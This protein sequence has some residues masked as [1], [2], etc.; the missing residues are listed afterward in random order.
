M[1]LKTERGK[2]MADKDK[3]FNIFLMILIGVPAIVML[4]I[5]GIR[6]MPFNELIIAVAVGL[7]GIIWVLIRALSLRSLTAEK[8]DIKVKTNKCTNQN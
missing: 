8:A 7:A 4:S 2:T 5:V 1:Q 3:S 6:D